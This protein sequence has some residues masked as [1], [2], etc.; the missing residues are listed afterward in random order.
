MVWSVVKC[1][2]KWINV[3]QMA[4]PCILDNMSFSFNSTYITA[5]RI[6]GTKLL[7]ENIMAYRQ[8]YLSE[9][10]LIKPHIIWRKKIHLNMY[11]KS[12][13]CSLGFSVLTPN[14]WGK[15]YLGLI[16]SISWPL[17][18]LGLAS[19]GHQQPCYWLFRIDRSL[20]NSRRNLNCLRLISVEE[21]YKM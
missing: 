8:L 6:F 1:H 17:M 4:L 11:V 19:P 9:Q 20:S 3:F 5:C 10:N 12:W 21:W 14:M 16:R 7:Y 13:L 2:C 18:P 15:S